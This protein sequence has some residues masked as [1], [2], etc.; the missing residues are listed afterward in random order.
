MKGI[1]G[2]S[3]DSR[4]G[5][6]DKVGKDST[7]V[8]MRFYKEPNESFNPPQYIHFYNE[9]NNR[10]FLHLTVL[11]Q[12]TKCMR[13]N[14]EGHNISQ[15]SLKFCHKCGKLVNKSDHICYVKNNNFIPNYIVREKSPIRQNEGSLVSISPD[16][17]TQELNVTSGSTSSYS[18]ATSNKK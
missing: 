9:Y 4:W 18:S 3:V 11:G 10:V 15:C 8:I 16:V 12:S 5:R 2:Q 1:S 6:G 17:L 13:C 14:Q 7:Q